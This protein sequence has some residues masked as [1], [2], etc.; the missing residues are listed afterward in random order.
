MFR[1]K[2]DWIELGITAAYVIGFIVSCLVTALIIALI[3]HF[4]GLWVWGIFGLIMLI[5][6]VHA[7]RT[8]Y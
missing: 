4:I 7:I 5:L 3:T 6:V 2:D 8:S 1:T